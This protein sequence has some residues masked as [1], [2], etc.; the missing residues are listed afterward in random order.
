[1]SNLLHLAI[2]IG[3]VCGSAGLAKEACVFAPAEVE[4]STLP[5]NP[6]QTTT[7]VLGT[8]TALLIA[9]SSYALPAAD[10]APRAG[11]GFAVHVMGAYR[12]PDRE[13]ETF[14]VS[15]RPTAAALTPAVPALNAQL[16]HMA[17]STPVDMGLSA[18]GMAKLSLGFRQLDTMPVTDFNLRD[19]RDGKREVLGHLR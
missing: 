11:T 14:F 6:L 8:P 10:Y 18:R 16:G 19:Y 9:Q 5:V 15:A 13:R 3:L 1:M 7:H 4:V 12:V 2:A 17:L